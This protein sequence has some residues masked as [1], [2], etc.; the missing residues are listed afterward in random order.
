[1]KIEFNFI[2]ETL[3]SIN[4][5]FTK[6]GELKQFDQQFP[7]GNDV[8]KITIKD[9]TRFSLMLPDEHT[10]VIFAKTKDYRRIQFEDIYNAL[11]ATQIATI[12][13]YLTRQYLLDTQN[14]I[15]ETLILLSNFIAQLETQK[16]L[17]TRIEGKIT[18][19]HLERFN[20]D[21]AKSFLVEINGLANILEK[22][23]LHLIMLNDKRE[24]V[25]MRFDED[26]AKTVLAGFTT[27]LSNLKTQ[28]QKLVDQLTALQT[29][30]TKYVEH[31]KA[32]TNADKKL[33]FLFENCLPLKDKDLLN[34]LL[35][36]ESTGTK[37]FILQADKLQAMGLGQYKH[38]AL[39]AK[40]I[41]AKS[42][43][44][45]TEKM[46]Q[47]DAHNNAIIEI[48]DTTTSNK[49]F[50]QVPENMVSTE[51]LIQLFLD[52]HAIAD[53]SNLN[54]GRGALGALFFNDLQG[55]NEEIERDYQHIHAQI[56]E[57]LKNILTQKPSNEAIELVFIGCGKGEEIENIIP[58]LDTAQRDYKIYA[59]DFSD[60][61]IVAAKK[62]PFVQNKPIYFKQGDANQFEQLIQD[63]RKAHNNGER[64]PHSIT[65][66]SGF[67]TRLVNKDPCEA[68]DIFKQIAR[69]INTIIIS[70]RTSTLIK[71]ADAKAAGF[72]IHQRTYYS[73]GQLRTIDRYEAL[74]TAQQVE[75]L[76]ATKTQGS[77]PQ[78]VLKDHPAPMTI[79][80]YLLKNENE[81]L[82]GATFDLRDACINHQDTQHLTM[83]QFLLRNYNCHVI[84]TGQEDWFS[85]LFAQEPDLMKYFELKPNDAI[86]TLP[87]KTQDLNETEKFVNERPKVSNNQRMRAKE[88]LTALESEQ[89]FYYRR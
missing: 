16:Q 35:L 37:K 85:T 62:Q 54:R 15:A 64:A 1:M 42:D 70:G 57:E 51:Q 39:M 32:F 67:L 74:T 79:V 43:A 24:N 2:G 49:Q 80:E 87:D 17:L 58:A 55:Y 7:F 60:E 41:R 28:Q 27:Y 78:L 5:I 48:T 46:P 63:F 66:A 50:F 45:D 86:I 38:V 29:L 3:A 72:A 40:N 82:A 10:N 77:Y 69:H 65:I 13:D 76:L 68:F 47:L 4:C 71:R 12:H 81:K 53:L 89:N 20:L 18:S 44:A 83:L 75:R 6:P 21:A 84:A 36:N 73:D 59:F 9:E 88:A 22:I 56:V 61:N 52:Q 33:N 31:S 34:H 8:D 14:N 19:N 23:N 11:T 26:N 25:A 30:I